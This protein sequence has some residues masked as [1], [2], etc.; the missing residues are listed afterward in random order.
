MVRD[1]FNLGEKKHLP[2][3]YRLNRCCWFL[4]DQKK[5]LIMIIL[6]ELIQLK[7]NYIYINLLKIILFIRYSFISFNYLSEY[8]YCITFNIFFENFNSRMNIYI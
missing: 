1:A 2:Y 8:F 3:I 5:L 7:Q 4:K 6:N